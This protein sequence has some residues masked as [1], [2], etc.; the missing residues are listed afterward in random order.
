V[1]FLQG[2]TKFPFL[3]IRSCEWIMLQIIKASITINS[4][5]KNKN[6]NKNIYILYYKIK[7]LYYLLFIIYYLKKIGT[8]MDKIL[9]IYLI[10]V[11]GDSY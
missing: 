1:P 5:N 7:I 6:K 8:Q 3:K 11:C 10:V 2:T 4:K 9:Y